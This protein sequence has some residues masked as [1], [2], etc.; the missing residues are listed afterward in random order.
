M[1]FVQ[2]DVQHRG[3][4]HEAAE[5]Q[6]PRKD[7][8]HDPERAVQR[9]GRR[10]GAGHDDRADH[11]QHD[12]SDAAEQRAGI[13]GFQP[14]RTFGSMREVHRKNPKLKPNATRIASGC[15]KPGASG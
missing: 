13:S 8:E 1:R 3:V 4:D 5:E 11:L 9:G 14:T 12:E 6:Q 2:H 15:A 7:R 10:D